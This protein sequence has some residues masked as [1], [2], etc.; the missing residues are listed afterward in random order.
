MV[1]HLAAQLREGFDPIVLRREPGIPDEG[2][3]QLY[4]ELVTLVK[5]HALSWHVREATLLAVH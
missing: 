5:F 3:E 4:S 2:M 1:R